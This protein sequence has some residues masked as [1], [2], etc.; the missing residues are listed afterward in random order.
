VEQIA[1]VKGQLHWVAD[2]LDAVVTRTR[3]IQAVYLQPSSLKPEIQ[4][5]LAAVVSLSIAPT[6]VEVAGLHHYEVFPDLPI[7]GSAH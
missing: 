3:Y 5:A 4:E 1:A 2:Q 7:K 6:E